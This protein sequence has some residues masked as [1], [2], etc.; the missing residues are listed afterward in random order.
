[1]IAQLPKIRNG[2]KCLPDV[3]LFKSIENI[4]A[5]GQNLPGRISGFKV[6]RKPPVL[7]EK[8]GRNSGIAGWSH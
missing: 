5:R 8:S 3:G 2:V 4:L 1:M 7:S 6:I